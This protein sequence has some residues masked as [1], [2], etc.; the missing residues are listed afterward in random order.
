MSRIIRKHALDTVP[1]FP[2]SY[3]APV[4]DREPHG[5]DRDVTGWHIDEGLL[6]FVSQ[7]FASDEAYCSRDVS[8]EDGRQKLFGKDVVFFSGP[9]V[10][11]V[12]Y[13]RNSVMWRADVDDRSISYRLA[14]GGTERSIDLPDVDDAVVSL[15]ASFDDDG[16]IAFAVKFHSSKWLYFGGEWREWSIGDG[17]GFLLFNTRALVQWGYLTLYLS[18]RGVLRGYFGEDFSM[19]EPL[20]APIYDMIPRL[21]YWERVSEEKTRVVLSGHTLSENIPVKLLS[22]TYPWFPPDIEEPPQPEP[23]PDP[24]DVAGTI[25]SFVREG[26]GTVEGF[27]PFVDDP[28]NR[29]FYR[30][31][32]TRWDSHKFHRDASLY[33]QTE[34]SS[35][36]ERWEDGSAVCESCTVH[37]KIEYPNDP[38]LNEDNLWTGCGY[39]DP[40]SAE[41]WVRKDF[42]F[43]ETCDSFGDFADCSVVNEKE[44]DRWLR[45]RE[46]AHR[47][48]DENGSQRAEIF[49]SDK[50]VPRMPDD[51][52]ESWVEGGIETL[53]SHWQGDL[54][55]PENPS[56]GRKG[57][58]Y[59]MREV[60][61][62]IRFEGLDAGVRYLIRY[63][64][65][66][67]N[68]VT[69]AESSSWVTIGRVQG[70]TEFE[71]NEIELPM[72]EGESWSI[73]EALAQ[74]DGEVLP[75]PD[76]DPPGPEP[77][78]EPEV[79][80]GA[81]IFSGREGS[82]TMGVPDT[83]DIFYTPEAGP[84][85]NRKYY[86]KCTY[87][88]EVY[89]FVRSTGHKA[90]AKVT[91]VGYCEAGRSP[92]QRW[93]EGVQDFGSWGVVSPPFGPPYD[94]FIYSRV[95]E[96]KFSDG[97]SFQNWLNG[98]N[99]PF[100][101]WSGVKNNSSFKVPLQNGNEVVGTVGEIDIKYLI[102]HRSGL[103][104]VWNGD[105]G[106]PNRPIEANSYEF[107]D[108]PV[109][110]WDFTVAELRVTLEDEVI[111]QLPSN[112]VSAS[113]ND[114]RIEFTS[115]VD[116]GS[117]GSKGPVYF[118]R[119]VSVAGEVI[120]LTPS[121][122]YDIFLVTQYWEIGRDQ[123]A[124]GHSSNLVT[125]LAEVSGI[126]RYDF[127]PRPLT[128]NEA[129]RSRRAVRLYAKEVPLE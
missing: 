97:R 22:E 84:N 93:E 129:N 26:S 115:E 9:E 33:T 86:R 16:G 25:S 27:P 38:E 2:W 29:T 15:S 117:R 43:I 75:D 116:S 62:K 20:S 60:R 1:S 119:E 21:I 18:H 55:D 36:E 89:D 118:V 12:T 98:P 39:H 79:I 76:P 70:V 99:S 66:G 112:A 30:K 31:R 28:L 3:D 85:R 111:P 45:L 11:G 65:L 57:P 92:L 108:S 5:V 123:P 41:Y 54:L 124:P 32:R 68:T 69:D 49:L 67:V 72:A 95:F 122:R 4:I 23:E 96:G 10:D 64:L 53:D 40:N 24:Q 56:S 109:N 50:D 101:L 13:D 82:G 77:D 8:F 19:S 46:Y 125:K 126:T 128:V 114:S 81:L 37:N 100:T 107:P 87:S 105:S 90:T 52:T 80:E 58:H 88:Y 104:P 78:P 44:I 61:S 91:A 106:R 17:E 73:A 71:S 59:Y 103:P 63:R 113:G 6:G 7:G 94:G 14:E 35:F 120:G 48:L 51:A 34:E 110:E 47:V 127:P 102:F 74:F 42:S 121:K 83:S